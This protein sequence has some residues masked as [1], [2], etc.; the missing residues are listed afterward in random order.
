MDSDAAIRLLDVGKSY[1]PV[2]VLDIPALDLARG[3][4]VAVVGENGAGK[5]TLMGVLSGT[6][7][8]TTGTIEIAGRRLQAGR[9]DHSRELGVAL[10]AQEFPLVGQ[11]SVAENLLLGRRP[12]AGR[13][14]SVRPSRLRQAG[15][16]SGG[17]GPAGRGRHDRC[18]RGPA[19]GALPG[20]GAADDRDRQGVGSPSSRSHP[21]RADLLAG[22][23][24]G[25]TGAGAG[26]AARGRRRGGAVHRAPAGRGAGH[27]RP[28]DRA[29]QRQAGGRSHPG[30]GHRGADDPGDGRHRSWPTPISHRPHRSSGP[31]P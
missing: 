6:V 23:G 16:P 21:R 27:R 9:P 10:V 29:A 1:G 14:R 30:R 13:E 11:L 19:G 26:P 7:T 17:Q 31:P 24:R 28:G 2:K 8:P 5:S 15:H 25:R 4:I 22:T 18:G 3:Q 12:Q 20:P